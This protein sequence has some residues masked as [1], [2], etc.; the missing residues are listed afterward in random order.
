[1]H[2]ERIAYLLQELITELD[3]AGISMQAVQHL[4]LKAYVHQYLQQA[5]QVDSAIQRT[6]TRN[7]DSVQ[8]K[9]RGYTV[10]FLR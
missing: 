4:Q 10:S 5:F 3:K 1:M 2:N 8:Q 7:S 9:S 6:N